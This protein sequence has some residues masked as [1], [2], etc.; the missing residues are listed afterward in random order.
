MK[1]VISVSLSTELIKAIDNKRGNVSRSRELEVSLTTLYLTG[2]GD[3]K[4]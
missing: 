3:K 1:K 2:N 4:E